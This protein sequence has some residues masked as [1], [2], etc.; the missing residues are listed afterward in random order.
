MELFYCELNNRHKPIA[1]AHGQGARLASEYIRVMTT[2]KNTTAFVVGLPP[3][4]LI[5]AIYDETGHDHIH[6]IE[7]ALHNHRKNMLSPQH[8]TR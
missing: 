5:L 2:E 7:T 8:V 1:L 4:Q 3:P 6:H